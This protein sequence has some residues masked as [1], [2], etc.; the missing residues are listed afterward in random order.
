MKRAGPLGY[1]FDHA[2]LGPPASPSTAP[3]PPCAAQL[4]DNPEVRSASRL[5]RTQP[6]AAI[7]EQRNSSD[8]NPPR[9]AIPGSAASRRS[10]SC[11]SPRIR[12]PRCANRT[13]LATS[14]ANSVAQTEKEN[15][16]PLTPILITDVSALPPSKKVR[17][18]GNRLPRSRHLRQR[19]R[20]RQRSPPSR[21]ACHEAHIKP[22]RTILFVAD[23]RWKKAKA[24]SAACVPSS[25]AYKAKI[26]AVNR[27]RRLRHR[28]RHTKERSPRLRARSHHHRPRR[29][30][31]GP[32]S[33]FLYPITLL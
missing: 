11:S 3:D 29:T 21:A 14:S 7:N 27:S 33:A 2:P 31:F 1:S 13:V 6:L 20:P 28:P 25:V 24:I 30:Q 22:R 32:T 9:A 23:V 26:K 4:A 5:V 12:R 10:Q 15:R 16:R 19:H 8:R 18:E 17:H